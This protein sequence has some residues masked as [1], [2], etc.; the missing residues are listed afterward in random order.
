MLRD[1]WLIEALD[2]FVQE[3]SDDEALG[4][5]NG[6]PAGA[7]IKHFVFVDLARSGAVGTTDVVGQNFQARH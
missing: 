1:R 5:R 3:A 2:D 4:D 7:K 6:N